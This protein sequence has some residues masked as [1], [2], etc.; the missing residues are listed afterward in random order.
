MAWLYE[1]TVGAN[2]FLRQHFQLT[3]EYLK[4]LWQA[5]GYLGIRVPLRYYAF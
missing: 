1:L 4:S 3:R 5:Y 2:R